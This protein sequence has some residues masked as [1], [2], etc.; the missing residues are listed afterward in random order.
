VEIANGTH[1]V[2]ILLKDLLADHHWRR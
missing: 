2:G 1:P